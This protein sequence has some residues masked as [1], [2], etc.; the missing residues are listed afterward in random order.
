M[1]S[2]RPGSYLLTMAAR[3]RGAGRGGGGEGEEGEKERGY[4][5]EESRGSGRVE[6]S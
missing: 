4:V 6:A 2:G 5:P 1:V 3:G